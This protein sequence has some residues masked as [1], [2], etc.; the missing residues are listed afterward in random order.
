MTGIA[1]PVVNARRVIR[2]VYEKTTVVGM[3]YEIV[4]VCLSFYRLIGN[5]TTQNAERT[6]SLF[7]RSFTGLSCQST[8]IERGCFTVFCA[9]TVVFSYYL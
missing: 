5:K 4:L 6:K 1:I 3:G 9:T 2:L 7:H 8:V